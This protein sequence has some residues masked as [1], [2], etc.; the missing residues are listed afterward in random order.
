MQKKIRIISLLLVCILI[1]SLFSATVSAETDSAVI[2]TIIHTNDL[3]GRMDA[4]PYITQLAAGISGNV[5]ILDAGDTLHGQTATNLSKGEAMVE[6]MNAVGYSAMVPGNHDFNFGTER[7]LELSGLM[8]FPLLAA[9]V[10]TADGQN[11][12]QPYEIFTLDGVTVGVFGL[13]TPETVTRADPRFVAGLTF[14]DPAETAEA[15]TAALKSEGCDIIIALMHMGIDE[16]SAPANRSDT[17]ALT[18]GIDVI[19]DGHSHSFLENGLFVGDTLI[20]QADEHG[21]HIGIVEITRTGKTARL[22]EVGGELTADEDIL[23]LI[24]V[25]NTKNE[26][27]T[28]AVVGH[29]P[30]FLDGER[31]N[32]RTGETNLANLITDSMIWATGADIAFL[33]GGN[34]RASIEA[35]EITMGDVLTM[36]PFSNLLVTMELTGAELLGVLEHG[37]SFYPEPAGSHI[38]VSGVSFF[39]DPDAKPGARV[40]GVK[41]ANGDL[42]E[43]DRTYTVATIEFL[44][45]RGDGYGSAGRNLVYFG[46]DADALAD[47]LATEPTI[48]AEPEGRVT[49]K[50]R[51]D[52]VSKDAW[53]FDAVS[54]AAAMGLIESGGSFHPYASVTVGDAPLTRERLAVMLSEFLSGYELAEIDG[55]PDYADA[56]LIGGE[57][58][59]AVAFAYRT[60]LMIGDGRNFNPQGVVTRAQ[61]VTVLIN[62]VN[63]TG[64]GGKTPEGTLTIYTSMRESMLDDLVEGFTTKY[65]NI[66]VEV[67]IA[68]AGSLM[69]RVDSERAS[70]GI[71]GDVIWTSELPDFHYMR[72]EGLLL[73]YRPKGAE[74]IY[75]PRG[76]G[77]DYFLPARLGTLGIAYNT[78]L[79]QT[80][81]TTWHDLMGSDFTNGFA[82]ADPAT[83]GTSFVS[84]GLLTEVFGQQ[85][86][87]DLRANG[88]FVGGS[89]SGVVNSVAAGEFAACL[90]V[91]YMVF[92]KSDAGYPIAIAYPQEL[93]VIPSPVAIFNDTQNQEIAK[94]FVDYLISPEAQQII[95]DN[96]TLPVLTNIT[97]PERYNVPTVAEAM[98]RYI[99]ISN[100]DMFTRKDELVA[101]FLE[102]ME[103]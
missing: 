16:F 63:A 15:I 89:S 60:R 84:I 33:T 75:D 28:A 9:N 40:H 99:R 24:D 85:F 21:K 12:F 46:G 102:I 70:G 39:F 73:K 83:S 92:D 76:D 51:F 6:V 82:I 93:I 54:Q 67:H 98:A 2:L 1:T 50:P 13:I 43:A 68:G 81:P 41:L 14:A 101:A 64:C 94:L 61:A 59:E 47:Y 11:L 62:I 27:I 87:R 74:N 69:A 66:I 8:D 53:Y 5:L 56:E 78:D 88:A 90:A 19:I 52:D 71:L 31:E 38:Q 65:P 26:H 25:V 7:L 57:F 44:A 18:A 77:D 91:D 96:G 29:T 36:V 4:A 32:I 42:I 55:E 97:V 48:S 58:L 10:K 37:V 103:N 100:D 49:P 30:V 22:I 79:V 45:F 80:S 3:H 20:A 95:A 23:A 35:G 34:I 72:E 17:I 86:F